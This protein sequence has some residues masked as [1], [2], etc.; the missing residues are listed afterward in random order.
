[1]TPL[2]DDFLRTR[3]AEH[4]MI[5]VELLSGILATVNT[6]HNGLPPLEFSAKADVAGYPRQVCPAPGLSVICATLGVV[7]RHICQLEHE[8]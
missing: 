3:W 6:C 5:H 1:M 2:H 7:L 8:N 4:D